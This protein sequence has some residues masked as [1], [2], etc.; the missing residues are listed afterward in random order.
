MD[1]LAPVEHDEVT[2]GG[3]LSRRTDAAADW[4]R[5]MRRHGHRWDVL[6]VPSV[7]GLRPNAGGGHG[8]WARAVKHIVDA[9]GDLSVLRGVGVDRRRKANKSGLF[10]WRDPRVTAE[11]LGVKGAASA[12]VLKALLDV[13][14]TPGPV[15][16]RRGLRRPARSGST[17]RRWSSTSISRP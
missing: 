17:P 14:R 7:D 11:S 8:V 1:R 5:R 3:S 2:P 12:P 4:L 16:R 6:P 10:D 15:V 13:N 9:G